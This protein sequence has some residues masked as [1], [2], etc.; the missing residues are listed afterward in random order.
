LGLI[1]TAITASAF[2]IPVAAFF[3]L[4][5]GVT[6]VLYSALRGIFTAALYR[7]ARTGTVPEAFSGE[8][9]AGAFRPKGG[10][11]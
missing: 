11:I 2:I 6:G 5:L 10:N 4:V 9:I 3:V 8:L 7:Y 1:W